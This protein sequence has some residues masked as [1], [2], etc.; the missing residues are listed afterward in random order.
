[1]QFFGTIAGEGTKTVVDQHQ[2]PPA[3]DDDRGFGDALQQFG[4][5]AVTPG[6]AVLQAVRFLFAS[7]LSYDTVGAG[8]SLAEGQPLFAVLH[9]QPSGNST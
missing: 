5:Q 4:K 9:P 7:H 1:M 6:I 3:V 2:M 8:I